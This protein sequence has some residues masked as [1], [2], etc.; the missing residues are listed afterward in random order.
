MTGYVICATPRSGSTL[1]CAMLRASGVAGW[2]ESWFRRESMADHAAEWGI[3][4]AA[5]QFD[6]VAYRS[7]ALK[8]GRGANGVFGLRL[9]WAS[10][11]EV[12]LTALGPLRY[13]WLQRGDLV[14]Q[15]ISRHR[16]E[17]S[18]TWH[19]GF[20]EAAVPRIP[21]YDF[22]R[23]AG[24]LRQADAD[25]RNWQD[26]FASQGIAPLRPTYEALS[27]APAATARQVLRHLGLDSA[28]PLAVTN[29]RMADA[30]SA[31]WAVRFRT[32]WAARSL[33]TI[34]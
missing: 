20:E 24:W 2:P 7:A 32:D 25:N 30:V 9:M 1:L 19:L 16:A 6:P 17:V 23:I 21:V 33:G 12:D 3:A 22:D 13:I 5:G 11:G 31:D 15:A 27:A 18:G 14:A 8:A 4:G 28:A 34:G 10:M 29:R 26:W